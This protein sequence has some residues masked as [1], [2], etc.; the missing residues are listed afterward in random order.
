[1]VRQLTGEHLMV[2]NAEKID[3]LGLGLAIEGNRENREQAVQQSVAVL[4]MC[5]LALISPRASR[6]C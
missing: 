5:A 3:F 1:M 4:C 6:G 2:D